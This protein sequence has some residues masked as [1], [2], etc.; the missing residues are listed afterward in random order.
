MSNLVISSCPFCGGEAK[1][2]AD[3]DAGMPGSQS[4]DS[5]VQCKGCGA[6]GPKVRDGAFQPEGMQL[7]AIQLWNRSAP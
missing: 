4:W 1:L 3:N 2:A 6:R 5:F 7:K